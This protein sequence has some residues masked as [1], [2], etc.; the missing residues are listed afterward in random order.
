MLEHTVEQ[1]E[2]LSSIAADYGSSVT[3]IWNYP[4][5]KDL[6]EIRKNPNILY[7]GDT[8]FIPENL[9]KE[10]IR[11]TNAEHKFKRKG[12][13]AH[14]RIVLNDEQGNPRSGIAYT[15]IVGNSTRTGNADG[16]GL[17]DELITR[18]LKRSDWRSRGSMALKY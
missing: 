7:P 11:S 12:I 18:V 16:D 14:L 8:V 2:C 5:N 1:G 3:K 17:I 4:A 13:P 9:T 6:R 15:M 10:T